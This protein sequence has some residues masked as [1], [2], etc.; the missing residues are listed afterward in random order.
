MNRIMLVAL[1]ALVASIIG[2]SQQSSHALDTHATNA[3]DGGSNSA[4]LAQNASV[5]D[6]HNTVCPVSGDSVA[7]SKLTEVYDGKVY[8]FC[9]DDCPDRFKADPSKYASAVAA[10]PSK[11]GVK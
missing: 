7:D 5:T 11:Y 4:A 2:C 3:A 6:L 10:D 8:H 9:C 1:T